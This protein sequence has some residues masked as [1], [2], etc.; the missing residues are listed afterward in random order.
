MED[1]HPH[2]RQVA[3]WSNGHLSS[4][5]PTHVT[6]S[7][8]SEAVACS[9]KDG[10]AVPATSLGSNE[11]GWQCPAS[12]DIHAIHG[13]SWLF[14]F[15]WFPNWFPKDFIQPWHLSVSSKPSSTLRSTSSSASSSAGK[16]LTKLHQ[17]MMVLN[18]NQW[19]PGEQIFLGKSSKPLKPLKMK[20]WKSLTKFPERN[21]ATGPETN[22]QLHR[23]SRWSK[24]LN[25]P[26]NLRR[27]LMRSTQKGQELCGTLHNGKNIPCHNAYHQLWKAK[28]TAKCRKSTNP[29]ETSKSNSMSIFQENNKHIEES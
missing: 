1:I 5:A 15:H 28:T 9:V 23:E 20:G 7:T 17:Q 13:Y 25:K 10:N 2:F 21:S 14:R 6:C 8:V 24:S 12:R 26:C 22:I 3:A 4:L 18:L 29:N 11:T 19:E 27:Q 16:R